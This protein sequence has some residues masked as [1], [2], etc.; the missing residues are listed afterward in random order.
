MRAPPLPEVP[1]SQYEVNEYS[2][3]VLIDL[4][5][6]N[7]DQLAFGELVKRN[8]S[9]VRHSL[10]QL[11]NWNES[12]AD[13]LA[14]ETFI[15]AYKGLHRFNQKSKF[16]SWLYRIAYNEFLQHCRS[17]QSQKN[18]AEFEE[19]DEHQHESREVLQSSQKS[20]DQLQHQLAQLLAQLEPERRS[21][22]HLL[23]HRQCT[24]QE[25][26]TNM[27]IPLGT[28]KTHINRGRAELQQKLAH[29]QD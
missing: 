16:S 18:Y 15:R 17:N 19:L 1:S 4:A 24:Q 23:L 11:S 12:L 6:R 20:A 29:W 22:L 28:V 27:G 25:I 13:D 2:E 10:R 3:D 9:S 5:V 7:N 26:A 21:V 14:Q 8:Q